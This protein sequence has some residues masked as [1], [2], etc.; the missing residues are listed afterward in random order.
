MLTAKYDIVMTN[1]RRKIPTI[2][3]SRDQHVT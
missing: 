3:Q 1:S 2:E